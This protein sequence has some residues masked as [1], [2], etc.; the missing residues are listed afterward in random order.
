[1]T[2]NNLLNLI[3]PANL[4]VIFIQKDKLLQNIEFIIV[5]LTK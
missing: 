3:L 2:N 1:M 4:L 5:I